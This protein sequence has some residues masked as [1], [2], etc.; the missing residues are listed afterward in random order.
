MRFWR[1]PVR[2]RVKV[3]ERRNNDLIVLTEK[4]G[5]VFFCLL[6]VYLMVRWVLMSG[7][8]DGGLVDYMIKLLID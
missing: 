1:F 2:K 8:D 7:V 4:R 3:K 5:F 6:N